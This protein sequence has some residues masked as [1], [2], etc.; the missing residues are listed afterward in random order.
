MKILHVLYQSIPNISGSSIRSKFIVEMQKEIGLEPYVITSHIQEPLNKNSTYEEI[1]GVKYY[2]TYI[3]DKYAKDLT[4]KKSIF[5]RIKKAFR[6]YY[7]YKKLDE[8]TKELNPDIIHAHAIFFCGIPSYLV[9]KKNKKKFI[10]EYRSNWEDNVYSE[11][12]FKRWQYNLV[13]YLENFTFKKAHKIIC[14]N[15]NLKNDVISRGIEASKIYIVP[16]AVDTRKFFKTQKDIDI[17][18]KFSIEEK[19]VIGFIGSIIG[20][21]G[22]EYLVKSAN[23]LKE[24]KNVHFLI[25][26]SGTHLE[27]LKNLSK[28]LDLN[29]IT[30]TGRVDY[31]QVLK[32]YSVI[33]IFVFPRINSKTSQDVTPLKPLEAMACEKVVLASNLKAMNEFIID[34]YNGIL[35]ESENI[36]DL[37]KKLYQVITNIDNYN[38]MRLNARE[39]VLKNRNWINNVKI[40]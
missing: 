29:N 14:I 19:I 8:V 1:N 11:G 18:K 9:A 25:V 5:L 38:E 26:G 13:R 7:F 20:I 40:I 32:Y 37:T 23:N 6:M 4:P 35:F 30:F 24:L 34:G 3:Y 2:R 12:G 16:N 22:I 27:S 33:D 17:L 15:E 31:N 36:D 39:Y 10:Y 21:E 28:E